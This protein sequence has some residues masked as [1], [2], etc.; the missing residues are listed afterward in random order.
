MVYT[1]Y[2]STHVSLCVHYIC[3]CVCVCVCVD[4]CLCVFSFIFHSTFYYSLSNFLPFFSFYHGFAEIIKEMR[5]M[6]LLAFKK[7]V[8][9]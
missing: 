6:P 5:Q 8:H 2:V 7:N 1:L 9:H 4:V 3:V